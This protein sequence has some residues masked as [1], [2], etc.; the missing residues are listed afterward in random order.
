[1][2][3]LIPELTWSP[4]GA[5]VITSVVIGFTVVILLLRRSGVAKQTIF[6]TCL[7]TAVCTL[8]SSVMF[9][10][11]QSGDLMKLGFSG[12]G[13]AIGM[14]GGVLISGL[15]IRDKPDIVMA[16]FVACAPLMYGLAK[17]GCLFAGCCHGKP[18]DGPFAIVYPGSHGGSYFPAQIV[19]MIVFILIFIMGIILIG[20][21]K[22]KTLA[23]YIILLILTPVR[24]LLE[25]LRSYH[26]GTLISSGQV[27]VLIAGAIALILVTVWKGVLRIGKQHGMDASGSVNGDNKTQD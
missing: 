7:L 27:T 8:V 9:T 22:N 16:S 14:I 21:M 26:E 25:Y 23:I 17:F 4:Y 10:I 18:Y 1:M 13:A 19:D 3:I 11:I 20:K 15:I 2:K 24:F 6:Y 12:L 5:I